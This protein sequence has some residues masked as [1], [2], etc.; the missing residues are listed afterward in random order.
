MDSSFDERKV[1]QAFCCWRSAR[2]CCLSLIFSQR[3]FIECLIESIILQETNG[4]W[5]WVDVVYTISEIFFSVVFSIKS[6]LLLPN[7][8][9]WNN[10][11]PWK[12]MVCKMILFFE[13]AYFQEICQFQG[14]FPGI[15]R[16]QDGVASY[17]TNQTNRVII[18]T[19]AYSRGSQ[20]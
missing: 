16:R 19:D 11:G 10:I 6:F 14:V 3:P 5:E 4:F 7:Y 13:M 17:P 1:V 12:S 18:I 2:T 9:P 20:Q 15:S 8:P